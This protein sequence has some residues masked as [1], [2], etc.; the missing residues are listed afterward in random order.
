[1]SQPYDALLLMSF[2]GPESRDEVM[3]FL[4][5]VLRGRNIPHRRVLEVAEHY[6]EFGGASPINE[7]NRKL[8]AALE[9]EL[10]KRGPR[11]PIYWGN[12][13]WHPFI[14]DTVRRMAEDGVRRALAFVTSAYSSYSG[15]RQYREDIQKARSSVGSRAPRVDKIR[16]FYNHPGF[17]EANVDHVRQA[18]DRIAEAERGSA[19]LVFSAHSIPVSMAETCDY[20]AQLGEACRLVAAGLGRAQWHLAYQSRSGPPQRPWLEPDVG[21]LVE[22]LREQGN[23]SIVVSPIGFIS[24]HMEVIYDLDRELKERCDAIGVAM[25]RAATP[26]THSEFVAMIREL[27]LERMNQSPIRRYLGDHGASHDFCPVDCCPAV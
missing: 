21:D 25:V 10:G 9:A 27:I 17:I 4:E 6:Y 3:P 23:T 16:V 24:D 13:N 18:F 1:M 11:L 20:E 2:G 26:G 7:C 12:R 5:N 8:I 15:C 14:N 22:R 19:P